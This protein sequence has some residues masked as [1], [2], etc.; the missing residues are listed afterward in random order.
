MN[1]PNDIYPIIDIYVNDRTFSV[2]LKMI[3]KLA[4]ESKIYE[5]ISIKYT[6]YI[7]VGFTPI[8]Y[9]KNSSVHNDPIAEKSRRPN[10][11]YCRD[12]NSFQIIYEYFCGY[13]LDLKGCDRHILIN[14]YQ[15]CVFFRLNN[16]K[17]IVEKFLKVNEPFKFCKVSS[18]YKK[19]FDKIVS[20]YVKEY[21]KMSVFAECIKAITNDDKCMEYIQRFQFEKP[22]YQIKNDDMFIDNLLKYISRGSMISFEKQISCLLEKQYGSMYSKLFDK[23]FSYYLKDASAKEQPTKNK[24]FF[25]GLFSGLTT[26]FWSKGE[27]KG[28]TKE[29][30]KED[31]LVQDTP[32]E[33][34]NEISMLVIDLV[35]TIVNNFTSTTNLDFKTLLEKFI[36]LASNFINEA[37]GTKDDPTVYNFMNSLKEVILEEETKK[38]TKKEGKEGGQ[39]NKTSGNFIDKLLKACEN[40]SD[41]SSYNSSNSSNS[42]NKSDETLFDELDLSSSF[43]QKV[44]DEVK[45]GNSEDRKEI[46]DDYVDMPGLIYNGSSSDED[47]D[48]LK[49][50]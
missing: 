34:V 24:G 23:I 50:N 8:E 9:Y 3:A 32:K 44:I 27:T 29:E 30:T 43:L 6:K 31:N 17:K 39:T 1:S 4:S 12:P 47:F 38:V 13:D 45:K 40:K 11:V 5:D 48:K 19:I 41:D 33:D 21:P 26:K 2:Q 18:T 35:D 25:S 10:L 20:V 7:P 15:D 37:L 14:L 42:S 28:E 36:I 22:K 46:Q 49:D 16:L